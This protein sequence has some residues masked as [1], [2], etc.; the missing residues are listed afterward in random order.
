MRFLPFL[1]ASCFEP[2][3]NFLSKGGWFLATSHPTSSIHEAIESRES[4]HPSTHNRSKYPFSPY[5]VHTFF[6]LDSAFCTFRSPYPSLHSSRSIWSKTALRKYISHYADIR[7]LHVGATASPSLC[8]G[9]MY[10][11]RK[12]T[13]HP[14]LRLY[15]THLGS[16]RGQSSSLPR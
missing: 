5:S 7:S 1:F 6:L 8:T 13:I 3:F 10:H 11:S 2:A 15:R 14:S 16:R 4:E 12:C 9:C